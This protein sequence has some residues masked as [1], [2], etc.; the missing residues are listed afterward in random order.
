M[1]FRSQK[2]KTEMLE[3]AMATIQQAYSD[4]VRKLEKSDSVESWYGSLDAWPQP[5]D[6]WLSAEFFF[7]EPRTEPMSQFA[8]RVHAD[9][10]GSCEG[11]I[12]WQKDGKHSAVMLDGVN[13]LVFP[14]AGVF[15]RTQEFTISFG[16]KVPKMFDR[17][18]KIFDGA[19]AA[20]TIR[21]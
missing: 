5:D 9:Q 15:S 18:T 3:K 10:P 6:R 13:S 17:A 7:D 19:L 16:L 8:N 20:A 4:E 14:N 2:Q 21:S 11:T 12:Q 1:L